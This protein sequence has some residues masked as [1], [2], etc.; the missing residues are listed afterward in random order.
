[1]WGT[2]LRLLE[3]SQWE[4]LSVSDLHKPLG[5]A[6]ERLPVDSAGV[7]LVTASSD[8]YKAS[9]W[10][11]VPRRRMLLTGVPEQTIRGNPAAPGMGVMDQEMSLVRV[12]YAKR[13][14]AKEVKYVFMP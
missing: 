13:V 9:T 5:R 7:S 2:S 6:W 3:S 8:L 12:E 14:L 11:C 10:F 4:S 1:M